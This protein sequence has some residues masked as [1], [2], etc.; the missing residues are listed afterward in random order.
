MAGHNN[1]MTCESHCI[2]SKSHSRTILRHNSWCAQIV[3]YQMSL[4][5]EPH[6]KPRCE[7]RHALIPEAD[8]QGGEKAIRII[9]KIAKAF[10]LR[11]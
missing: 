3:K 2:C 11:R 6:T 4:T 8:Q 1:Q 5:E 7:N 9:G 10:Q